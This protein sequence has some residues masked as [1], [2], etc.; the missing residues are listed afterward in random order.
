V[1]CCQLVTVDGD[2]LG[3]I[4]LDDDATAW[5]NGS[6]IERDARP[7]MRVGL[8]SRLRLLPNGPSARLTPAHLKA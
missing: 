1:P 5:P 8:G 3:P 4:E 7:D 2:A 6:I